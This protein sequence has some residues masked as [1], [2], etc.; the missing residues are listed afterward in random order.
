MKIGIAAPLGIHGLRN[1]LDVEDKYLSYG[2]E[3]TAVNN[4]IIGLLKKGHTVSAYTLDF[5]AE[6]PITFKGK[7]LTVYMGHYRARPRSRM[8]DF[9]SYESTQIKNFIKNDKP[10]F[11]HAHWSYEFAIGTILS[12]YPHLIT[13]RDD[14]KTILSI[15]KDPYRLVR[16]FMDKWVRFKG[17]NF[18]VASPYMQ[19]LLPFPKDKLPVIPNSFQEQYIKTS[20]SYPKEMPIRIVT[21]INGWNERKNPLPAVR[22]FNQLVAKSTIPLEYHIYGRECSINDPS[23]Q[24]LKANNLD[25]NIFLHGE[26]PY[27]QLMEALPGYDILVHPS[28][29]ESFGNNLIEA[30]ASGVPVVA[31]KYAGAV[32]WVLNNGKSGVLVDVTSTDEIMEG[33]TSLISNPTLYEKLSKEGIQRVKDHFS[34]TAVTGQYLNLYERILGRDNKPR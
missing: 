21:I 1:Y 30:M 25:K 29:E 4:L 13:F 6:T 18:N 22:A 24:W 26:V 32:P 10:D 3:A 34:S 27:S 17:K 19:E 2:L 16:Y 11:V 14:A 7:N 8:L 28:I 12:K 5:N 15:H 33:I 20:K 9:F 31:G 23:F